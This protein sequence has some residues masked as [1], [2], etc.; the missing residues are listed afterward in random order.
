M[1]M[2]TGAN[3]ISQQ[4]LTSASADRTDIQ[5]DDQRDDSVET[6]SK[7]SDSGIYMD[8]NGETQAWSG[9][10]ID[11][12]DQ[13]QPNANGQ[14][15]P[16]RQDTDTSYTEDTASVLSN[17][18]T[19]SSL[20]D[21]EDEGKQ[22]YNIET[23]NPS[24]LF[25]VPAEQHPEI[26]PAE[27]A[28]WLQ[29][30]GVIR[31][32]GQLRVRR[33]RSILSIS[34]LPGEEDEETSENQPRRR[35]YDAALNRRPSKPQPPMSFN[36]SIAEEEEDNH[37]TIPTND[38][39]RRSV[40]L[41]VQA[42][43]GR[44]QF[45]DSKTHVFD[46]HS[47]AR[48][49]SPVLVPRVEGSL[50]RRSNRTKLRRTSLQTS[51]RDSSASVNRRSSQRS[52]SAYGKPADSSDRFGIVPP[53]G[54]TLQDRSVS[55]SELVDFGGADYEP[56]ESQQGII[57][58]VH[59]AENEVFS[60]IAA[61]ESQQETPVDT[62][63]SSAQTHQEGDTALIDGPAKFD[64]KEPSPN[65]H[66][67]V[68]EKP[69]IQVSSP[70]VKV[71]HKEMELVPQRP[72]HNRSKSDRSA[73]SVNKPEKRSS[74]SF[75]FLS[76]DKSKKKPAEQ[77]SQRAPSVTSTVTESTALVKPKNQSNDL[78]ANSA[79]M[80]GLSSLFQRTSIR[81]PKTTPNGNFSTTKK[82]TK[83][84]IV[85]ASTSDWSRFPI[86]IE[87]AIYRLSHF[88]LSNPRRPL[89]HQVLISNMMF[90]YLSIIN[91]QQV[92]PH[93]PQ[94]QPKPASE[95]ESA[96]SPSPQSFI[97]RSQNT[98]QEDQEAAPAKLGKVSKF[99]NASKRRRQDIMVKKQM[100]QQLHHQPRWLPT[101][102]ESASAPNDVSESETN[103]P[104]SRPNDGYHDADKA[105]LPAQNE[106]KYPEP[107]STIAP[108][109]TAP[110]D[111]S[112][113][114]DKYSPIPND[115]YQP[116]V[117]SSPNTNKTTITKA[118]TPHPL[119]PIPGPPL[120]NELS[121][122]RSFSDD[123]LSSLGLEDSSL[124]SS[125]DDD[126]PLGLYRKQA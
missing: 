21:E 115:Q 37:T 36:G 85:K 96:V 110:S 32:K 70:D 75:K 13:H 98:Y 103:T 105:V 117:G 54:I 73:L 38:L 55:I 74:W 20:I 65:V 25:W 101:I 16:S 80:F 91:G 84:N 87:R 63:L 23:T 112:S 40:S 77:R 33:K 34:Y 29:T 53:G 8:S 120:L 100:Q 30:H 126:V 83:E 118:T 82:A 124:Q 24:R 57:T 79:K 122:F 12:D 116:T 11:R 59:D 45:D 49:E 1:N 81:S 119:P 60:R 125:E 35:S 9:H 99:I 94:Q 121:R 19:I 31:A 51:N 66:N 88:K 106:K 108:S 109:T 46:R 104:P 28:N 41:N 52:Q 114:T 78:L 107:T 15:E 18:T 58:R 86:H 3:E 72:K 90:W 95:N 27:F 113:N 97:V 44:Q 22:V 4:G 69:V 71:N 68:E 10:H 14:S 93:Q 42:P 48:D 111:K 5:Q 64:I 62:E 56:A 50:L 123:I 26:A 76:D 102:A 89:H 17:G 7:K 43:A 92:R 6:S 39:L 2:R 67:T 47:T 61:E